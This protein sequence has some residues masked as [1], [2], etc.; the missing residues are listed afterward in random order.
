MIRPLQPVFLLPA[1]L[2]LGFTTPALADDR[3][4]YIEAQFGTSSLGEDSFTADALG[5]P[6]AAPEA[7][8]EGGAHFGLALGYHITPRWRV[9]AEYLQRR[10]E[11]ELAV[12]PNGLTVTG[13]EIGSGMLAANIYYDIPLWRGN[14]DRGLSLMV[15]AGAGYFQEIDL[16]LEL[17]GGDREF[18]GD[19]F[20][21]QYLTG[22]SWQFAP[23]WA[24][25]FEI[26][27]FNSVDVE[28]QG[29]T[30]TITTGYGPTNISLGLGYRF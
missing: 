18:S 21:F 6:T 3:R 20:G 14:N 5:L 15:G 22:L 7:D 28:L 8:F 23:R 11:L 19:D 17:P 16:E 13:G 10:D 29:D 27:F 4:F 12:F 1:F 24:A 30:G 9:E 25:N 2:L 26:R